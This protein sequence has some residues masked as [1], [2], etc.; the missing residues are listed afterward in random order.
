MQKY[1]IT[2]HDERI[3]KELKEDKKKWKTYSALFTHIL[4]LYYNKKINGRK[5]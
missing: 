1:W 5:R 3:Q 4:T 2:I